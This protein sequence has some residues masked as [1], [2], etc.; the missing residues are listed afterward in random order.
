MTVFF[1]GLFFFGEAAAFFGEAFFA[2]N[3]S[4]SGETLLVD[5]AFLA[6][7]VFLADVA[8]FLAGEA[9]LTRPAL[10]LPRS[11][12]SCALAEGVARRG[13]DLVALDGVGNLTLLAFAGEALVALALAGVAAARA[14]AMAPFFVGVMRDCLGKVALLKEGQMRYGEV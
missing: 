9:L 10:T 3:V 11:P 14:F 5:D 8:F 1:A 7:D 2:T 13:E 6:G 4:S 12:A